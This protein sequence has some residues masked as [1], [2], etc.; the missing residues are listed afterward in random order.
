M[1]TVVFCSGVTKWSY[2]SRKMQFIHIHTD[3]CTTA[4]TTSN[5]MS[6]LGNQIYGIPLYDVKAISPEVSCYGMIPLISFKDTGKLKM[7]LGV[8]FNI[9]EK[10]F[11]A[12]CFCKTS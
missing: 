12:L 7:S 5:L 11:T 1:A 4:G 8:N 9:T 10:Y 6:F 2:K 3:Y